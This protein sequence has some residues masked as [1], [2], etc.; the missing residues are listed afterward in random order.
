MLMMLPDRCSIMIGA[1][2]RVYQVCGA[3]VD[4]EDVVPLVGGD[5]EG[6]VGDHACRVVDDHVDATEIAHRVGDQAYDLLLIGD[7][8]LA[9]VNRSR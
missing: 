3:E 2:S 8:A 4:V 5:C 1:T 9:S 6:V 7:V